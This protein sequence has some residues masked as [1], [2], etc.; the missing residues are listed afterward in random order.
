MK[1]L[2]LMSIITCLAGLVF[3]GCQQNT[4]EVEVIEETTEVVEETIEVV[5]TVSETV[6]DELL[7][8]YLVYSTWDNLLEDS[9][10]FFQMVH[11]NDLEVGRGMYEDYFLK[12]NLI[13]EVSH[14][15]QGQHHF[16]GERFE[17]EQS[18]ND[19]AVAYWKEADYEFIDVLTKHVD[20]MLDVLP[21]PVPE[22]EDEAE[23][24]NTNY[25]ELGKDPKSYGYYQFKFVYNAL[26]RNASFH[27]ILVEDIYSDALE[28]VINEEKN[29][30]N[31]GDIEAIVNGY[32][33]EL[34]KHDITVP[35]IYLVNQGTPN[36]QFV[37][38]KEEE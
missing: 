22:G 17:T 8:Y 34:L 29:T 1:K 23:Y 19:L 16:E 36:I 14:T 30:Y 20:H 31:V 26:Q 9:K 13:H 6:E 35:H 33:N 10:M 28:I 15:I 4:S 18:A 7:S 5:E 37:A 12:F 21:S 2:L 11:D 27:E 3:I 24:F 38:H 32:M 25:A